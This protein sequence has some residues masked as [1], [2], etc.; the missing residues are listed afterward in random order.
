MILL[1]V[2]VPDV[3]ENESGDGQP[4]DPQQDDETEVG[5]P[6]VYVRAV[7]R[8]QSHESAALAV[9]KHLRVAPFEPT[10]VVGG[11][12]IYPRQM[13]FRML[14]HGLSVVARV[15]DSKFMMH[16]VN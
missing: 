1:T 6:L 8:S 10:K 16:S 12:R 14:I 13:I 2:L 11:D 4:R 15:D 9:L 7:I 5:L 3:G